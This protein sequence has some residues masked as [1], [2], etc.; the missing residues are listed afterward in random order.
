[1]CKEHTP[2]FYAALKR[3]GLKV[4]NAGNTTTFLLRE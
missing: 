1:M 4:I 2:F 3:K